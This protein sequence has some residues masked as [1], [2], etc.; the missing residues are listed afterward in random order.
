MA[1]SIRSR[2]GSTRLGSWFSSLRTP[3]TH[4]REHGTAAA[5][6]LSSQPRASRI[7][8]ASRFSPKYRYTGSALTSDLAWLFGAGFAPLVALL[9][10]TTFGLASSGAYLLSGAVCTVIALF[11]SG[12]LE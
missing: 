12:R 6:R 3:T 9:L 5:I 2:R 1:C 10:A 8:I 7:S 11:L 4:V